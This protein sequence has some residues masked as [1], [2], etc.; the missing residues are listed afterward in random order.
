MV[1][2]PQLLQ[3]LL[4]PTS[5]SLELHHQLQRLQLLVVSSEPPRPWKH[6]NRL[7][8]LVLL[9]RT[10]HYLVLLLLHQ[11][12]PLLHHFSQEPLRPQLRFLEVFH[13][14]SLLK[15]LLH[16]SVLPRLMTLPLPRS[17]CS[18]L[19]IPP[20]HLHQLSVQAHPLEICLETVVPVLLELHR[21]H[22]SLERLL[23]KLHR[24]LLAHPR[25]LSSALQQSHQR[26]STLAVS[27]LQHRINPLFLVTL[28]QLLHP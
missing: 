12:R 15:H 27:P 10:N 13:R 19:V 28:L 17:Q 20:P 2:L 16:Y 24:S 5:S 8:F 18:H 4:L 21:V 14:L 9:L 23:L 7:H 26:A 25:I 11:L 3:L 1:H 22:H 6:R